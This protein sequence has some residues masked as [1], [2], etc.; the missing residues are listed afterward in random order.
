MPQYVCVVFVED[1]IISIVETTSLSDVQGGLSIGV[2][3]KAPY[4]VNQIIKEGLDVIVE[5]QFDAT[6]LS[7]EFSGIKMKCYDGNETR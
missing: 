3:V 5:E 6:I 1:G 7:Q 2:K 4:K